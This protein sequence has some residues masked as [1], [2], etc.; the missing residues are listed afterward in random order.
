[1]NQPYHQK[2]PVCGGRGIVE[3]GFYQA[4]RSQ[5]AS[6]N[7]SVAPEQCRTC[8]GNG[9]LDTG[10]KQIKPTRIT[11]PNKFNSDMQGRMSSEKRAINEIIDYLKQNEI[12]NYLNQ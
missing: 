3:V 8:G 1:M 12:I 4:S 2:C 10:E 6:I 7:S 5:P 9:M 11:L